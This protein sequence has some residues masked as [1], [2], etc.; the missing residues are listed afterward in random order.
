MNN[1]A[2][3]SAIMDKT[4]ELCAT[5]V[6]SPEFP[7]FGRKIETFM[8]D[9]PARALYEKVI[10]VQERLAA[11][12]ESG[13]EITNQDFALFDSERQNLLNNP[14][15]VDFLEAQQNMHDI[16]ENINRYIAKTFEV[17]RIP[18]EDDFAGCGDSCE[19]CG[20]H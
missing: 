14:I 5:I 4:R 7:E 13:E 20:G 1:T 9:K 16:R 2:D 10:A 17:G 8:N 6:A 12:Q 11:Q 3:N 19:S 15:A 18:T